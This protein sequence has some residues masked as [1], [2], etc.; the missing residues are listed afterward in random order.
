MEG[1]LITGCPQQCK[2][3]EEWFLTYLLHCW[4]LFEW[5]P[6]KFTGF[7][8]EDQ[9]W[10]CDVLNWGRLWPVRA[11]EDE[12]AIEAR[13]LGLRFVQS[14]EKANRNNFT[15]FHL[16]ATQPL[17]SNSSILKLIGGKERKLSTFLIWCVP[18]HPTTSIAV[19][20]PRNEQSRPH[21]SRSSHLRI[22]FQPLLHKSL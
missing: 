10:I 14:R 3:I 13:A 15:T 1:I 19:S 5:F 2:D 21:R 16:L 9:R 11:F 17:Q 20:P 7:K 4:N 12:R 6:Q 22:S 18:R 8:S